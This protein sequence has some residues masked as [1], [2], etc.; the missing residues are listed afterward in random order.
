[1]VCWNI[2]DWFLFYLDFVKLSSLISFLFGFLELFSI[3]ALSI[4]I[5]RKNL[6]WFLFSLECL[7]CLN[8][9]LFYLPTGA[10]LGHPL[11][12]RPLVW[13]KRYLFGLFQHVLS[14]FLFY[15]DLWKCSY[16]IS[17]PLWLLEIVWIDFFSLWFFGNCLNWYFFYF[18]L[19][20]GASLR[21]PVPT[22][23]L[24]KKRQ[25]TYLFGLLQNSLNWFL[26]YLD[27][28]KCS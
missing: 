21:H 25:L 28:W 9:F 5:F 3:D 24:L 19:A 17:F 8:W 7:K 1:M 4:W 13:K 14:R 26:F 11:P 23:L 15:L 2:L 6:N 18:Y 22:K 20:T 10:S 12:T 27:C 16:L